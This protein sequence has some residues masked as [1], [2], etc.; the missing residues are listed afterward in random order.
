MKF[1]SKRFLKKALIRSTQIFAGIIICYLLLAFGLIYWPKPEPF[2]TTRMTEEVW[3]TVQASKAED[4]AAGIADQAEANNFEVQARDSTLLKATRYGQSDVAIIVYMHGAASNRYEMRGSAVLLQA[5]TGAEVVIYDH[6]GH[7]ESGGERTDVKYIGQY[8]DDLMDMITTLQKQSPNRK[9]IIAGHSMGGGIAMRYALKNS[10]PSPDAYL[11]ISPS[12]G[13]GPT[14]KKGALREA[15]PE[16]R[17]V[18]VEFNVKRMIGQAMLNSIGAHFMDHKSI[19]Y[20]NY[21]PDI[22]A[23]SYRAVMSGQPTRPKTSDKALQAVNVPLLVI[24][25][26]NDKLFI[27]ENFESFV[28][29]NSEGRTVVVDDESHNSILTSADAIA[30]IRDWYRETLF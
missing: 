3:V 17:P 23:Y 13:E 6:R 9:L 27:V 5:A 12:F 8:E 20:F 21:R 16:G 1:L 2:E 30:A 4:F 14:Q 7:G 10:Y 22:L 25:G 29:A 19:L 11:L 18:F 28:S 15:I 26:R 24:V